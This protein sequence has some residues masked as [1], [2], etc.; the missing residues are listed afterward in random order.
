M[1]QDHFVLDD[2]KQAIYTGRI[3]RT[4]RDRRGRKYTI[5]GRTTDGRG[6][7]V[8]CRLTPLRRLRIITV[9]ER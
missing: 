6:V 3:V 5:T 9:Y 7:R 8:V 2:V 1:E 4:Q